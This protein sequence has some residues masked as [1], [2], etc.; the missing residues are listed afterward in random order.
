MKKLLV[1]GLLFATVAVKAQ[2][3]T[4]V[5]TSMVGKNLTVC[6][7][8]EK[9]GQSKSGITFINYAEKDSPYTGVIYAK[10]SINFT[11]Y[12]PKDFLMGKQVCISGVVSL[13]KGKPQIVISSPKQIRIQEK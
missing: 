10:D 11:E 6:G 7:Y 3:N 2:S 12:K 8:V 5:D 1:I 9:V 4:S 13:F